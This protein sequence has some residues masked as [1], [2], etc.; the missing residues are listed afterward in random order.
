MTQ[1]VCMH[2]MEGEGV[3]FLLSRVLASS[4][5]GGFSLNLD[6]LASASRDRV[7]IAS[8]YMQARSSTTGRKE[9]PGLKPKPKS[10][11]STVSQAP[12]PFKSFQVHAICIVSDVTWSSKRYVKCACP[13]FKRSLATD[14]LSESAR[15][16]DLWMS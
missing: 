11:N 6:M 10:R 5:P 14:R 4:V 7:A 2:C 3:R 15:I 9:T 13:A 16:I 12:I 8:C 1:L